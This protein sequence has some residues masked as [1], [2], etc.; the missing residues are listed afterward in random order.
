MRELGWVEVR[1]I[2]YDRVYADDDE[3]RLPALARGPDLV[4]T[5][6]GSI[7]YRLGTRRQASAI[8]QAGVA[9]TQPDGRAGVS[10][11][12]ASATAMVINFD[13]TTDALSINTGTATCTVTLQNTTFEEVAVDCALNGG[14]GNITIKQTLI[15]LSSVVSDTLLETFTPTAANQAAFHFDFK[16]C[17]GPA[18]WGLVALGSGTL[19]TAQ[20]FRATVTGVGVGADSVDVTVKFAADVFTVPEPNTLALLGLAGLGYSR[21]KQ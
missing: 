12:L 14:F 3:T 15:D 9:E 16:S 18:S 10:A 13:E 11:A 1:N 19:E 17:D 8:P 7:E 4:H 6:Y 5:A 2:V 20:T 21:R